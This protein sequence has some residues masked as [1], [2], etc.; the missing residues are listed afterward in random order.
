MNSHSTKELMVQD[1]LMRTHHWRKMMRRQ[2][3]P[4]SDLGPFY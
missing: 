2:Q 1:N 4:Q 3:L